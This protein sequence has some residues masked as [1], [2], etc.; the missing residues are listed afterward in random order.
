MRAEPHA[1]AP[2]AASTVAPAAAP[3]AGAPFGASTLPAVLDRNAREHPDRVAYREKDLGIWIE[4]PWQAALEEV[5]LAAAGFLE[6]GLR[7]GEGLLIIGDNR[8]QLYFGMLAATLIRAIPVPVYPDAVPDEVI[9]IATQGDARFALAE[10]QEQVDK[11]LELRERI[12][13]LERIV[14]DDPRGLG[15]YDEPALVACTRVRELGRLRVEREPRFLEG[16]LA[17]VQ[18][19]DVAVLLHSSGTTG[20][21]KGV[22]LTHANLLAAVANAH[23]AGYFQEHEEAVAYLPMAWVGDFTFSVAAALALRFTVNLPERQETLL[24]DLRAVGPTFYFAPPRSWDNLLTAVQVR[25]E[26]STRLKRLLYRHFM[27]FATGLEKARLQGRRPSWLQR[28]WRGVGELAIYGPLK[29][30]LGLARVQ[31][32][33][34]AGEAI[35]EDTFLYFRALGVNLKQF[36]GQTE[37]GALT[38]AQGDDEVRLETVGRPL[39]GAELRVDDSGEILVRGPSVFRGY[40]RNPEATARAVVDGWFHTGDAGY[41]D[42]RGHLVILGRVEDV[43]RTQGGTRFVPQ[44][45]ENR[46]KFSPYV[47]EAA[48]VGDR[49]PYLAAMICIDLQAVGHWAEVRGIAYTSYADLS[50]KP[51]VY[52]LIG[53]AVARVNGLLPEELRIRRFV[54]LHKEFDPDDG[55][56]TRTRKLRRGL[57]AERYAP[58]IEALYG[59]GDTVDVTARIVYEDGRE[60]ELRRTLRVE[61]VEARRALPA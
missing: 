39:P 55:E 12:P 48:V 41:L 34:T 9:H 37:N 60:G 33:F 13:V 31:R 28:L 19:G 30:Q 40:W 15:A 61:E 51:E 46:L 18:P 52:R 57:V 58:V 16:A 38:A 2:A 49:R 21:P 54:N 42:E 14:Y 59:Q 24:R 44:Y 6:L 10:D 7:P 50:Q 35:G 32:A 27:G 25:M 1:A 45:I 29:D 22:P 5:T 43:V 11:L 26:E 23:R 4:Y 47:R 17:Q 3:L 20:L 36:Y 53:Q 8:P 56:L